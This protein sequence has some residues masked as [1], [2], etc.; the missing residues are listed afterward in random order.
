MPIVSIPSLE[1][2]DRQYPL[3][4]MIVSGV[5]AASHECVMIACQSNGTL[6]QFRVATYGIYRERISEGVFGGSKGYP[7]SLVWH[8]RHD[9]SKDFRRTFLLLTNDEIQCWNVTHDMNITKLWAHRV[10]GDDGDSGIKKDLAGQKH[11]WLL[12]LQVDEH[13]K[14]FSVLVA[15]HCKDRVSSSSYTQYS[16]L[17]MHYK[18]GRKASVESGG[19]VNEP[20]LEKKAPLQVII[21]KASAKDENFLFSMRLRVG[22]KPSGSAVVLSG[23]GTATVTNY[24][25]GSTRLYQFD[26]PWDAGKVLDASVFPSAED[27]EEGAWVVLTEKA[28]VWAIPE[29]AVLLGGVE[30]PERSLSRKGSSNEGAAEEEK[31][32]QAFGSNIIPRRVSSDA[33]GAGDRQRASLAGVARITAQDEEAETL[34]GRLFHDFL[35]SGEVDGA[36]EKLRVKGAFEKDGET[37]VFARLSRSIVD[38][39]AKHWTTTRGAEF[40]ASAV[41]SSLLSDKQQKHQNYLQFIALSKC[42]EELSSRQRGSLLTIME[43]GEK[44]FGMVQLRELQNMFSQNR[45]DGSDSPSSQSWSHMASSLWDLIQLVGEKARRNTVLLMDRD[46]AEVFYSKVSVIEE[47]FNCLS[48]HLP[49]IIGG[50]QPFKIQMQRAYEL[51]NACTTVVQ[52]ALRYRYEHQTWYPSPDGLTPWNCQAVVRS[53]LWSIASFIMQLLKETT[54]VDM[55]TKSDLWSQ[56]EALTDILLDGYTGSITSK[57]ER[58]EEHKSLRAEYH[59]RTDELLGSLYELA[60]RLAEAKYQDSYKDVDDPELKDTIFRELVSPI[61]SIAK[62]HE[63]YQTLWDICYDLSDTVLLRS[64]MHD[65]VGPKGGFSNFVFKQLV[66]RQQYAKLL[67]LGEEFQEELASFLKDHKDLL[68]LHQIFLHQFSSASETFHAVALSQDD[69]SGLVI[70]EEREQSRITVPPSLADRRRLLNLSKIA[71]AAGKGEGYEM[72]MRRIEADLRILNLQEEIFRHFPDCEVEDMNKPLPPG[73]LVKMCLEGESR[74]LSL[75]AF[76]VFA[77][78]SSSFQSTNRKLLVECWK[79]A[80]DQDDWAALCQASAAEGWSDEVVFECLKKTILY[81]A[82]NRCYGPEAETYD[83][84]FDDFLPL[85]KE[86]MESPDSS[87]EGILM[88]HKDFPDAGKLMLTAIMMGKVGDNIIAEEEDLAMDSR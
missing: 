88:H 35:V 70:E 84:D 76:E 68:C 20:V 72:K 59:K 74:D 4:S 38:V 17:T 67:R 26:L 44:L 34:L 36:F 79:N 54:V 65:S 55:S 60:K 1:E 2:S 22:G 53:G 29:K 51:A 13:G 66:K 61:L 81:K 85:Q 6:W 10:V 78:T 50:E 80:A 46:N 3:N 21:P 73:D 16:L 23:D 14:E 57:I 69:G 42:H 43:H 86:D 52:A 49:D 11:I 28:G 40:V 82:S 62:R 83:G 12:D 45:S 39:L 18:P 37:N 71:A 32:S 31:R 41:V 15:T 30:P 87:V 5:S 9:L 63:G 24:W 77:W 25:R 33:W 27:T 47:L 64:L 8:S 75:L 58:G 56:L 48:L 19:P 7:R